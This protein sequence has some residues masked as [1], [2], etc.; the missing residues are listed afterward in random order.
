MSISCLAR[1]SLRGSPT[2]E[3]VT[4]SG[5]LAGPVPCSILAGQH[6]ATAHCEGVWSELHK[7]AS[8]LGFTCQKPYGCQDS[9]SLAADSRSLPIHTAVFRGRPGVCCRRQEDVHLSV[10]GE[11]PGMMNSSLVADAVPRASSTWAVH[12]PSLHNGCQNGSTRA[13]KPHPLLFVSAHLSL[14]DEETTRRF[15]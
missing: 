12:I 7:L 13:C 10:A 2:R 1:C 6:D 8:A 9:Y 3:S 15:F 14:D 11:Q 5:C 4:G